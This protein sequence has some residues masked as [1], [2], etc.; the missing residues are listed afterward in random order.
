MLIHICMQAIYRFNVN[1]LMK[2]EHKNLSKVEADGSLSEDEKAILRGIH[3][4]HRSCADR[5]SKKDLDFLQENYGM[6]MHSQ[7]FIHVINYR[8]SVILSDHNYYR[9]S[10]MFYL[11]DIYTL[12]S[13][14]HTYSLSCISLRSATPTAS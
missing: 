4:R 2:K 8:R 3:K 7:S 13:F 10:E 5:P 9:Y 11:K 1:W 12:Y 6:S 14:T